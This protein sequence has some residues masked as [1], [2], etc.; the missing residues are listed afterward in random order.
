MDKLQKLKN[1]EFLRFVFVLVLI[2][3]HLL[4][5]TQIFPDIP[6]Y[7]YISTHNTMSTLCVDFF[8]ILSGFFFKYTFNEKLDTF[9]FLKKKFV[10]LWAVVAFAVVGYWCLAIFNIESYVSNVYN[11]FFSFFFV[12]CIGITLHHCGP[13]WYI[14]VLVLVSLFYF[15]TYKALGEKITNLI[16]GILVWFAYCLTINVDNGAIS[17]H[18]MVQK[19]F[20]CMGLLR[21]IGGIGL[22]IF[23][24]YIWRKYKDSITYNNKLVYT[25]LEMGI[26][27]WCLYALISSPNS[28]HNSMI[29]IIAFL[30]L[31]WLFLIKKG[32][33]SQIFDNNISVLMG[34]YTYSIFLI[35]IIFIYFL[36]GTIWNNSNIVIQKY[37][38][39]SI[40]I[41]YIISCILGIITYHTIE[42]PNNKFY[43][44]AG[45]IRYYLIIF[46][47]ALIISGIGGYFCTHKALSTNYVY[48]FNRK[49]N[50]IKI[51]GLSSVENWGRW[52]DG[53]EV[54]LTFYSPVK[55][56]IN[57]KFNIK[58]FLNDKI[59][60]RKIEIYYKENL[61][62]L[63]NFE[64]DKDLQDTI[65]YIPKECIKKNGKVKLKFKIEN[66]VSPKELGLSEDGRKLGIGFINMKIMEDKN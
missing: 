50:N 2:Y 41:V 55:D 14:S 26:F 27:G 32:F 52:S 53:D 62:G 1:I 22:G 49:Y 59:N 40:L 54:K 12:D 43:K 38:L 48:N 9:D 4:I 56:N 29:F 46:I 30:I 3:C 65:V 35:H 66:P 7:N 24:F 51:S 61:I 15:C 10:R 25:I 8:F 44:N 18:V 36:G 64:L 19:D 47:S 33:V 58:P 28:I 17:Q 21:G 13:S 16:I 31:I 39:L 11:S 63:W 23:L 45:F 60:K 5:I 34:K 42:K 6:L 20:L 37:P 57:A